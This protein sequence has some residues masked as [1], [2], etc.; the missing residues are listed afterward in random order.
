MRTSLRQFEKRGRNG[1]TGDD[2]HLTV[3]SLGLLVT[4]ACSSFSGTV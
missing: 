2:V 3:L 4:G 1:E